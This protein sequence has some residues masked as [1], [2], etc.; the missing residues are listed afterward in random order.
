MKR[1][2]NSSLNSSEFVNK[3]IKRID[4]DDTTVF[5]IQTVGDDDYW[6]WAVD[7]YYVDKAHCTDEEFINDV[8]GKYGHLG[9]SSASFATPEDAIDDYYLN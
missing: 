4:D 7:K 2:L 5:I 8:D 6:Y 3:L 9:F 1:L